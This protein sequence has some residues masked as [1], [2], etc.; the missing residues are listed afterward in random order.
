MLFLLGWL[1]LGLLEGLTVVER[2]RRWCDLERLDVDDQFEVA[3]SW[4]GFEF[5]TENG[6]TLR[7]TKEEL[8]GVWEEGQESN[9]RPQEVAKE[10]IAE[11][12]RA[13]GKLA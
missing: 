2:S 10:L 4:E 8:R 5:K 13:R 3:K 9:R 6:M 7:L 11:G 1:V 12:L